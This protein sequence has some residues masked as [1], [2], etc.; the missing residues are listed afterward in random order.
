MIYNMYIM[1]SLLLQCKVEFVCECAFVWLLPGM[2]GAV[3]LGDDDED[4]VDR[5]AV[6][7][8]AVSLPVEYLKHSQ[9][10]LRLP[11]SGH[12]GSC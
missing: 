7:T 11:T 8:L 10:R 4:A 1:Y 3:V 9:Q 12:D 2:V 6:V 5:P